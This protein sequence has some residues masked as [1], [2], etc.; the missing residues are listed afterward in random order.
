MKHLWLLLLMALLPTISF[1]MPT[2]E[3]IEEEIQ[4]PEFS[5]A[6]DMTETDGFIY[7]WEEDIKA[8]FFDSVK[9]QK[10]SFFLMFSGI[11]LY[12]LLLAL[13]GRHPGAVF[14]G[15]LAL[16]AACLEHTAVQIRAAVVAVRE[17]AGLVQVLL[18]SLCVLTAASGGTFRA[19]SGGTVGLICGEIGAA[20]I[21]GWVIP[22][23]V[24]SFVTGV[25]HGVG[26]ISLT[27]VTKFF[28]SLSKWVLGLVLSL[29]VGAL[30][31]CGFASGVKDSMAMKTAKFLTGTLVP[32]AG[33]ALSQAAESVAVSANL[34]RGTVGT[35]GLIA[36]VLYLLKPVMQLLVAMIFYRLLSAISDVLCGD[37]QASVF[38][39]A[40]DTFGM[41]I[42]TVAAMG[43]MAFFAVSV[44]L[45]GVG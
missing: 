44:L 32:V 16:S 10:N 26:E 40:A 34:L 30:A 21:A 19:A 12:A 14:M 24:F 22:L 43:V 41:L 38:A 3:H 37:K 2:T 11:L 20:V 36:V 18:P 39:S 17:L 45:G 33:A 9:E 6:L 27:G 42:G 25:F 15:R 1:A 5:R 35:A 8:S 31:I 4:S 29:S 28:S 23:T 7:S 13:A